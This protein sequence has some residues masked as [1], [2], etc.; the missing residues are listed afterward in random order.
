VIF[1]SI[2]AAAQNGIYGCARVLQACSAL[3]GLGHAANR[4]RSGTGITRLH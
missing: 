2:A 3:G 1:E 4:Q